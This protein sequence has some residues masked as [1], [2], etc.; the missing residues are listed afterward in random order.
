MVCSAQAQEAQPEHRALKG[1]PRP[2]QASKPGR[3]TGQSA[4]C[5]KFVS[6]RGEGPRR[7]SP[8]RE[9]AQAILRNWKTEKTKK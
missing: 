4:R 1:R 8:V 9:E 6:E 7:W 5:P 2:N 3:Q